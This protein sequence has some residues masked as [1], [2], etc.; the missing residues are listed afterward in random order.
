MR[1]HFHTRDLD[2][3]LAPHLELTQ[4]QRMC[5]SNGKERRTVNERFWSIYTACKMF[6]SILTLV[7]GLACMESTDLGQ[8]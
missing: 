7:V 4:N 2:F 5:N 1:V 3:S 6:M 8:R